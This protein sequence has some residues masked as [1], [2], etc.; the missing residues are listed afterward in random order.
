MN[1]AALKRKSRA[2]LVI[3]EIV[4]F[5]LAAIIA[6]PI[7]LL[8]LTTFKEAKDL[9]NPFVIPN[10]GNLDN[11][12]EVFKRVNVPLALTN[13]IIITVFNHCNQYSDKL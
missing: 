4:L 12:F 6:F 5:V 8:F 13:T 10:F 1:Q 7:I 2:S 11:Y 3:L 9:Y